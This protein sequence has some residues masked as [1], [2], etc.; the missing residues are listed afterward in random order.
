MVMEK[1]SLQVLIS[2]DHASHTLSYR[3]ILSDLRKHKKRYLK[4]LLWKPLFILHS[5]YFC[6]RK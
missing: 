6:S 5:N 1:A 4:H 3:S 2:L